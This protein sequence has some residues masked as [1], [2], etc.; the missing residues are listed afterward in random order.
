MSPCLYSL[1]VYFLQ[2]NI[3]DKT[4]G[5]RENKLFCDSFTRRL[6]TVHLNWSNLHSTIFRSYAYRDLIGTVKVGENFSKHV[7]PV[8]TEKLIVDKSIA[9]RLGDKVPAHNLL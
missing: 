6:N 7:T 5:Y 3:Y 9:Y 8:S 2:I 1:L 4:K